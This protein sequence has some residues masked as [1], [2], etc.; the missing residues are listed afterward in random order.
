MPIRTNRGRAAV[1]RRLWSWPMRSPVHL[2]GT[3]VLFAALIVAL[4][5]GGSVLF[6]SPEDGESTVGGGSPGPATGSDIPESS[7]QALPTRLTEPLAVPTTA[8]PN[9]EALQVAREWA[10][11]WTSSSEGTSKEQWLDD[12][13]P[14]TTEEYLPRMRSIDLA[15]VPATRITGDLR[16]THSY[17]SSVDVE[18]PTDGPTLAITVIRTDTGWRVSA[19]DEVI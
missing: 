17:T 2:A 14:Y 8:P 11:V 13:R 1:Y 6:S 15:A 18:V 5:I 16:V 4:G 9:P 12:L 19:Y 3:L 7:R 10:S